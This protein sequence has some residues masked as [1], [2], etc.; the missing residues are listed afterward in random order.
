MTTGQTE[1]I[2]LVLH[3]GGGPQ[4]VVPIV[5]HLA[6]TMQVLAPTHPGWNGTVLP[7]DVTSVADLAGVYLEQLVT[8]GARGVVVVGSSIGGWLAL[9]MAIAA[10]GSERYAGVIGA[11]VDIDGVGAVVDGER[12]RTSSRWTPGGSPRRRGTTRSGA[13]STPPV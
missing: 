12:S 5:D 9:E 13:T 7:D 1:S 2:A 10:A 11:V 6:A 4:T 3:G 8:S